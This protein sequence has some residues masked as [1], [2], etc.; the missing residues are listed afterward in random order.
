MNAIASQV[1]SISNVCSTVWSKKTSKLRVFGFC[2]GNSPVTGEFPAQKASNAENISILLRHHES[3][4]RRGSSYC[5]TALW[6]LSC[7][8]QTPSTAPSGERI[9]NTWPLCVFGKL[10]G[11]KHSYSE[12]FNKTAHWN[13][14]VILTKFS[15]LAAPDNVEMTK[16][17]VGQREQ[18]SRNNMFFFFVIQH[19]LL[20]S[21]HLYDVKQRT[22]VHHDMTSV[23]NDRL[24]DHRYWVYITRQV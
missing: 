23:I 18:I 12:F 1:T 3:S 17:I 14:N 20:K 8:K 21:G 19:F 7:I 9:I 16:S 13:G 2:V 10:W 4:H 24:L 11:V 6:T 5:E 22:G 15:S